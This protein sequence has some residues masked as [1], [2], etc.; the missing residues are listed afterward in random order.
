MI[1]L[2]KLRGIPHSDRTTRSRLAPELNRRPSV[3]SPPSFVSQESTGPP[4]I[5]TLRNMG[6]TCCNKRS[7]RLYI[8]HRPGQ[9]RRVGAKLANF[10]RFRFPPQLD[11]IRRGMVD[12][13]Q[14]LANTPRI[15]GGKQTD[16]Q[17]SLRARAHLFTAQAQGCCGQAD[18]FNHA[19]FGLRNPEATQNWAQKKPSTGNCYQ[20]RPIDNHSP[21]QPSAGDGF[22][23][24]TLY[25]APREG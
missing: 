15:L 3:G 24:L 18:H 13:G 25:W 23:L 2:P 8:C 5:S 17:S 1:H 6:H 10:A 7:G 4:L 19:S 21:K 11:P 20:R 22:G 14:T 16:E 12:I 9:H